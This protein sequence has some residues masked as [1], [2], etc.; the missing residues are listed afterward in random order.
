MTGILELDGRPFADL[1]MLAAVN[2]CQAHRG[3]DES[4]YHVDGPV[5]L[6]FTRLSVIDVPHGQQPMVDADT[7]VSLVFNGEIYN[8]RELRS[9]LRARGH[10]FRTSS[11]TESL[12][13]G[14]LEWGSDVVH[15]LNGMFAF[16]IHDGRTGTLLLARD[17]LGIKPLHWAVVDGRFVFASEMKAILAVPGFRRQASLAGISSYLTFRQA[18]WG[19]S[20]FEG[21][22]KVLPGHLVEVSGG[23]VVDREY[24]QLP[25]PR[26][27]GSRS[28]PEWI[29]LA[30]EMLG[31][32]VDRCLVSEVPLGAY[33]S[34]G[35]DSSLVVAMMA[36][37]LDRPV[38]TFS[39]GYGTGAYDEG[40][41]AQQVADHVGAEHTHLVVGRE[42]YE[43][44][45]V[46]LIRHR[47]APLS[48]PQEIAVH[49]LSTEMRRHVTVALSGDGADELFGG[50]G[51]V[52]RSPLDWK[53]TAAL[54]KVVPPALARRI[55]AAHGPSQTSLAANLDVRDHLEH[56]YRMYHWVPFEEKWGLFSPEAREALQGDRA[57]RA[58]FERSFA[59]TADADPY[60]RV[61]HAFQHLHIGAILDK[62]DAIGMSASLEGRVPFVDHELVEA[63]VHMPVRHKMAWN[64]RSAQLRSWFTPA[65]RASETLDTTKT[66]LRRVADRYLPGTLTS[67]KKMGFPTPL[68]DWMR[69]GMLVRAREVLLDGATQ[70][71]GL[72]DRRAMEEFLR[73]PQ[74][75]DHD[76]YGKKV[77]M[78]MNVAIWMQEV[79]HS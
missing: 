58:P 24:W 53:K 74:D 45:L 33:L 30:D 14:Y 6:G 44:G 21:I 43:E 63:F 31:R 3:P 9:Q 67:R 68:D 72:F 57:V 61:L 4:G 73:R 51:R 59:R 54:Q 50:Y 17:R 56:F 7:R 36:R 34:G 38:R 15:R 35:L 48:I 5:G 78:Y 64:S 37:R 75:L 1:E 22:E 69:D 2:A 19:N 28:G 66:V 25:V 42:T 47:D 52:M 55:A 49:A 32:A 12:L 18:V 20:Y 79:V 39:V 77:W 11:D 23:R 16:G 71:D 41:F 60:D 40:A 46:P 8:F 76:F 26:P 27:D 13:R 10:V 62:V 65:F 29:D 70:R